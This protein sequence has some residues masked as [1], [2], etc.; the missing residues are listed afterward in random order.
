MSKR[1]IISILVLAI[2]QCVMAS[3]VKPEDAA[4]YAGKFMG[5]S[6]A[7]VA[8]NVTSQRSA[9]RNGAQDP[10][11]YVFNNPDGGWVIIASD[12]R[13]TPILA[14]SETGRFDSDADMPD[15][16]SSWMYDMAKTIDAVRNSNEVASDQVSAAW[17]AL[18]GVGA[19]E[20]G[21]KKEIITAKWDQNAPYN[22]LCPV[23]TGETKRSAVGCV[24]TAM[25]IAMRYNGWPEKGE[26]EIGG[27]RTQSRRYYVNKYSIDDRIYDWSRMPLTNGATAQWTSEEKQQVAQLMYDCGVMVEMDYTPKESGSKMYKVPVAMKEHMSYSD[28]ITLLA[29]AS[30]P[31]DE[32]FSI[33]K[34]EIDANRVVIY[35]A[36]GSIG[37]HAMICDGY[38]TDGHKLHMNWGWGGMANGYYTLDFSGINAN[39]LRN[40]SLDSNHIAVIGIAPDTST[41]SHNH[42]SQLSHYVNSECYGLTPSRNNDVFKKDM[43]EGTEL[44]FTLGW[45]INNT[46]SSI[47]KEF[48]VCLMDSSGT[49]IRQDGWTGILRV[50]AANDLCYSTET[51][52][53]RLMVTPELTDYFKLFFKEGSEWVPANRNHELFPD[54]DGICC[55][56]TPDPIIILPDECS[57][58]QQI[59][60]KLTYGYV[61]VKTV[62]WSVNGT[63]YNAPTLVLGSGTTE[64]RADV[65]YYDESEGTIM[66]TVHAK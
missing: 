1:N 28:K 41:V 37:G 34:D 32:W 11:F 27:Y 17:S 4:R 39:N 19:N 25:A 7:P 62:K 13:V 63:E 55:G 38:D 20:E 26:G 65:T 6:Y 2:T 52:T 21:T 50:P 33:I 30:Y 23:V 31:V 16:L 8:D 49:I 58:G 44:Q 36:D 56:V 47:T 3:V 64:I 40:V 43:V 60:L 51:H 35:S 48:K 61:P 42:K 10:E 66:A 22:I 15:N 54:A 53:S 5:I 57:A 46:Y 24:A 59:Q 14:Y 12:D 29:R 45:F 18:R 9:S